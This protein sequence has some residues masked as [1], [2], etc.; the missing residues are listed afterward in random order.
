ME[1]FKNLP[2]IQTERLKLRRFNHNDINDVFEYASETDITK[3]VIWYPHTSKFESLE[4]LNNI[5]E[6]Y[7]NNKPAPWAIELKEENKVIG[8]IGFNNF[9]EENSKAEIGFALSKN[10]WGKGIILEALL[11]I[12]DF[13]FSKLGLNRI[14]AYCM[15]E[16]KASV[17]V[18]E[19]A[20]MIYEGTFREFEK[21]K[22]K[23]ISAQFFAILKSDWEK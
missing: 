22:G 15:I 6:A 13:G 17:R 1:L 21:V 8:S 9:E 7:L 23:F 12:I 18:M 4:F 16:N 2:E 10:Y 20:G 5:V 19:K 11:P 14:E 3:F